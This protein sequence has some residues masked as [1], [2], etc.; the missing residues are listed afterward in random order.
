MRRANANTTTTRKLKSQTLFECSE[1]SPG[2][3]GLSVIPGT[4]EKFKTATHNV[5]HIG[6]NTTVHHHPDSKIF[7]PAPDGSPPSYK[8]FVHSYRVPVTSSNA[9]WVC[10]T[11]SYGGETYVSSVQKGSMFACQFHPEKSG[12]AGVDVIKRFLD[13]VR[14]S[15]IDASGSRSTIGDVSTLAAPSTASTL[16]KRVVV[17]LDVRSNDNGDLIVTKGDQYDVRETKTTADGEC[18]TSFYENASCAPRHTRRGKLNQRA[19]VVH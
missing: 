12:A 19:I 17:A 14:L 6:W 4:V 16:S 10:T 11:T 9:S 1:E 8:Y 15:S 2:V 18:D 13:A 5:P 7:P 3:S